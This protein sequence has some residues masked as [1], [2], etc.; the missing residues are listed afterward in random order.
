MGT[1]PV[2]RAQALENKRWFPL[3][4]LATI[5]ISYFVENYLRS[6]A[7]AL[8]PVLIIELQTSKAM[9]GLLVTAYSLI[10]GIMQIPAGM[11]T[12]TFGPRKTI[13]GFTALTVT[14]VALFWVSYRLELLFAAQFIIGVGCS[15]FYI[16][17]VT[18]IGK[19]FPAERRATAIGIL[20]AASGIGM[21]T[22]Y[23]GFPLANEFLGGWRNLYLIM[24]V[25]LLANYAMNFAIL[26]NGPNGNGIVKRS[27]RNLSKSFG[28][29]V[30][31]HRIYPFLVGYVLLSFGWVF[32]SWMPQFL[33][34][35]KSFT[36]LEAGTISSIGS[37]AGIPGC[38]A[39]GFISD[40][41]RRRKLPIV[42]FASLY[43]TALAAFI[44]APAGFSKV[45]FGALSF[46]ISFSSSLW[47]LFFSMVPEVLPSQKAAIGLGLVNGLGTM[48]FS[49]I[50]PVYGALIDATGSYY[51]SN[52]LVIANALIMTGIMVVFTKETY[53]NVAKE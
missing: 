21:F 20:S 44:L 52:I 12:D 2:P 32:Y 1:Q 34:D 24:G 35:T 23:M 39:M 3:L 38:I 4:I 51:L 31:D 13:L 19:W 33:I 16:N 26:K 9:M 11:F 46:V 49:F 6:A 7:S 14:G 15:V 8:T 47:I 28:E 43:T 18:M 25:V 30:K 45:A 5:C 22:S 50:T 48:G 10:Y 42:V 40:K 17:A 27:S 41:L 37:I 53:G 36:Y 29:V